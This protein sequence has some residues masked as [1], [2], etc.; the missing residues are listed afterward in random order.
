VNLAAC[1]L[2]NFLP[3][4]AGVCLLASCDSP[5]KKALRALSKLG[6]D[7]NGKAL[8]DAV[9]K[10][11]TALTKLLL[12]AGVHEGH[13]DVSGRTP[14]RVAVDQHDLATAFVLLDKGADPNANDSKGVCILGSALLG[15]ET[16]IVDRLLDR[17]A[18]ADGKMPGGETVLPWAIREGRL[19][20][21]SR[22]M[23]GG[24]DPH[25]KDVAGNS[26]VHVAMQN[27]RRELMT[28][29]LDRGADGG[30][31]DSKGESLLERA[32]EHNWLDLIPRLVK[33]GAD[34][35]A[36]DSHGTSPLE[37]S[38]RR[39]DLSLFQLFLS[40]GGDPN[41]RNKAGDTAVNLVMRS[42]WP[43]ARAALANAK[44]DF[45][46]PDSKG[47]TPLSYA[48]KNND[49][50]LA[51]ELVHHGATPL[52]GGWN[53]WFTR[54]LSSGDLSLMRRLLGLGFKADE[55]D[56]HGRLP[57]EKAAL[58]KQGSV[59][60][61]LVTDNAPAGDSLYLASQSGDCG[62]VEIL[63]ASGITP[64][65]SRAPWLDT[66]LGAA[67][68]SRNVSLVQ[69]LL[70]RGA[71]PHQQTAEGQPPLHLAIALRQ[72]E[73]VRLLL[74]HG[75]SAN[76]AFTVPVSA[77]FLKRVKSK[78][79]RW[80]L[81]SDR[82]VTPLMLAACCSEPETALTLIR[83]GA[84]LEVIA[85]VSHFTPIN[86]ACNMNDVRMM[87]VLLGRNPKIEERTIVISLS[88]QRARVYNG[89]GQEIYTTRVSTGKPGFSTPT[90]E[91][92][93]TNKHRDWTSTLYHASMP[94][95]QRLSCADFG[96]HQGVVP[97]YPAS[98][99][100]IRLPESS[101][102]KLFGMTQTGD[103]VKIIP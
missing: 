68:R 94:Y 31:L 42:N 58:L 75:V 46:S 101:A 17:G 99:G 35:N 79:M 47:L 89:I 30:S 24:M 102:I 52:S 19:A 2:R 32:M 56:R 15:G 44:A 76:A 57:V 3:L 12:Q 54:A 37:D 39:R 29:L 13:R 85:P 25:M 14:L 60:R 87:R 18:K 59:V 63:M 34:P 11:D 95:F 26:L 50:D 49:L 92:A 81:K 41:L 64:N 27:G 98:H 70:S 51:E 77:S 61:M 88:E 1:Q 38:I 5:E 16:A 6:V 40:V 93:I 82:N 45:N 53:P 100:C 9:G 91:Y 36:P 48:L 65:P 43:E 73:M 8:L 71:N 72:P 62:M 103:R 97:G 22:V 7:P 96:M 10:K 21:V 20:F 80:V 90:G 4:I 28:D 86:F 55:R 78:T 74:E 69:K 67:I 33:A 66:P 23:K 83:A 84:K